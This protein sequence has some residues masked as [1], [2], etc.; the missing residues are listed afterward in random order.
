MV[1][2]R[3][4][5]FPFN[6]DRFEISMRQSFSVSTLKFLSLERL[7]VA[8]RSDGSGENVA[9]HE[10]FV[11]PDLD[12]LALLEN[13]DLLCMRNRRRSMRNDQ[14]SPPSAQLPTVSA[15]CTAIRTHY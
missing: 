9:G 12:H 2:N 11:R 10:F 5:L 6:A 3:P 4:E 7:R 13:E 15:R 14:S 1:L 8:R